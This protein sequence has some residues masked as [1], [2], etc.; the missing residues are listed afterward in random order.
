MSAFKGVEKCSDGIDS[1]KLIGLI[2][3]FVARLKFYTEVVQAGRR[4]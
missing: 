3:Q 2:L 1:W 4:K